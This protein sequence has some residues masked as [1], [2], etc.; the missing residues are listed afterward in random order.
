MQGGMLRGIAP[1]HKGG[2][3]VG[4]VGAVRRYLVVSING[5]TPKWTV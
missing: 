5:G 4:A 3:A 2:G 1:E